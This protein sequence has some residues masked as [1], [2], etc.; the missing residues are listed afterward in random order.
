MSLLIATRRLRPGEIVLAL[1]WF[2]IVNTA[3]I[4]SQH[5]DIERRAGGL[6]PVCGSWRRSA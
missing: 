6:G 5:T 1:L 4:S 2:A 3:C